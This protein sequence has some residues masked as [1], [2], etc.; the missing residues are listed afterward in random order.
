MKISMI[1]AECRGVIAIDGALPV[2]LPDDL[3]WFKEYTEGKVLVMGRKTVESLPKRLEG[4]T[5]VCLTRDGM[6]DNDKC[7]VICI[8]PEEVIKW[9]GESG[10]EELVVAGGRE[11][12]DLFMPYCDTIV[13]TRINHTLIPKKQFDRLKDKVESPDIRVKGDFHSA[14]VL[15]KTNQMVVVEY[16]WKNYSPV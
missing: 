1:Y 7:D 5:V 8:N 14:D 4:R 13:K 12:Y 6:Y 15:F 9:A 2:H 3:Q 16:L 10:A 11:I